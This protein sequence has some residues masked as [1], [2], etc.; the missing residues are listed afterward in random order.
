[1]KL[2]FLNGCRN[3]FLTIKEIALIIF[4]KKKTERDSTTRF[5]IIETDTETV[6]LLIQMLISKKSCMAIKRLTKILTM[7]F[8]KPMIIYFQPFLIT[9]KMILI[10][11]TLFRNI[12][13]V[14]KS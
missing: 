6:G 13:R 2:A 9:V 12:E 7:T 10:E 14:L 8:P 11:L 1:M 3:S 4:T 5:Y